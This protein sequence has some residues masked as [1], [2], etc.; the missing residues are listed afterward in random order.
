MCILYVCAY[1]IPDCIVVP[2]QQEDESL[3]NVFQMH[4]LLESCNFKEFWVSEFLEFKVVRGTHLRMCS[5][6]KQELS[7]VF[8]TLR[9]TILLSTSCTTSVK[10]IWQE[11]Y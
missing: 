3:S 2:L 5:I 7:A 4:Q 1:L 6:C 10:S 11:I 8:V 9:H